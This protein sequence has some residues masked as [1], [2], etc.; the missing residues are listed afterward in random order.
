LI[1]RLAAAARHR[2]HEARA[3]LFL[4]LIQPEPGATLLDLG[5]S[6]GSFAAR[7]AA[8]RPDLRITVADVEP[9]RF[10]AGRRYGF[11]VADLDPDAPLPFGDHAFDVVFCNSVIEHVTMPRERCLHEQIPE[12][13]W[14]RACLRRQ[15]DFAAEIRRVG[16]RYFVQTPHPAFLIDHHLWLPFTGRLSHEATRRLVRLTD[17]Y[18]VKKCGVADWHLL[19]EHTMQH[20][21]PDGTITVERML[22]MR[23]SVIAWA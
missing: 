19:D 14:R 13:Q 7:I 22:G 8:R 16:R 2:S 15:A 21:F 6:T 20:L 3:S 9:T 17:R 1:A 12:T 18:W 23:K 5:G 4:R 11:A 10:E